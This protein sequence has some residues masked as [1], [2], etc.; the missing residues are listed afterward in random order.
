MTESGKRDRVNRAL[1]A[2]FLSLESGMNIDSV[3]T[4]SKKFN[5]SI[6][7]ISE[8][9]TFLEGSGGVE[10]EKRGQLGS[11]LTAISVGKLWEIA[12]GQPL[13]IAHT[14]PSNRRYEGLATAL[15][16]SFQ[17]AGI[18]SYFIFIR[19]SRT[20]INALREGRCHIAIASHYA[21]DGLCNKTDMVSMVLPAG[22]F[23]SAHHLFLRKDINSKQT[24]L[25]IAVDPESY[26]QINLSEIEFADQMVVYKKTNF[27]NIFHYLSSGEVDAAIWTED[28][29]RPHLD[30]HIVSQPLS[31]ATRAHV[32]NADQEAAL[33]IRKS[34]NVVEQ[35]IKKVIDPNEIITIQ[36]KV[37]KGDLIPEY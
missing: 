23:V 25:K 31:S 28:D 21:A 36:N 26:D 18:D 14:L 16:T 17:R 29:M 37:I 12:S 27:M 30:E 33:L 7:L 32:H 8:T 9:I 34:D 11:T 22:S 4:L 2:Y 5:A 15:K 6:G 10:I 24:G 19:G 20:R 1:A 13:V 35:I 3:R